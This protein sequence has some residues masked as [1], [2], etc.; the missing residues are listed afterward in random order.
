MYNIHE[1]QKAVKEGQSFDYLFFWKRSDKHGY[2]SNW[3]NKHQL[4]IDGVIYPTA[5]HWMMC[6]KARMFGDDLIEAKILANNDPA[7]AK[8]LGR[9]VHGFIQSTWMTHAFDI[10]HAGN[11]AKFGQNMVLKSKLLSTGNK[12]LVEA[13]PYDDIWG[14]KMDEFHPDAE[15]P[16]KWKGLNL[17]GF[18]LMKVR[19]DLRKI[20]NENC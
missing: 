10:V 12:I 1:L 7:I 15:N 18:V 4:E 9:K 5:E 6:E 19:D 14:I 3:W 2:M 17:L 8:G 13:S 16:L 11:M 20:D